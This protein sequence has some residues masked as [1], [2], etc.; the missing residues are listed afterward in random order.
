MKR[1]PE[2]I[3][4]ENWGALMTDTELFAPLVM[5]AL[6]EC[7][8]AGT[9]LQAG[10]P[11]TNAVFSVDGKYAVKLYAPLEG[12]WD[13]PAE[14]ACYRIMRDTDFPLAPV[15]YGEGTVDGWEYIVTEYING[16]PAR[17]AWPSMTIEER[18]SAGRFAGQFAR[19][20]RALSDP[21][22]EGSPLSAAGWE[23]V[24]PERVGKNA[25]KLLREGCRPRFVEE[26]FRTAREALSG[27]RETVLTHSDLTEDHLLISDG[28]MRIIDFAD[29]R[30]AYS[31]LEWPPIWFGMF[32][33]DEGAFL[34][35][36]RAAGEE[37]SVEDMLLSLMLHGYG[38]PILISSVPGL[39]EMTCVSDL[40]PFLFQ[41]SAV[42]D[43]EK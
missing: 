43:S 37:Y 12:L 6:A 38:A 2:S 41:K 27:T 22:P 7:G 5:K 19:A 34:E 25:E 9:R 8:L 30:M 39:R 36:L 32:S 10:Y 11:G 42:S 1:F 14:R 31:C 29:S 33:R 21:F 15:L 40:Y 13:G 16:V 26:F 35:Y 3:T 20:Y 18:I 28:R 4:W 17:E 23:K 24:I